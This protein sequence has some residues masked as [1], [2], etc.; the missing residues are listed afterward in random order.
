MIS[1][2]NLLSVVLLAMAVAPATEAQ[3][4]YCPV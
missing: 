1:C 3:S 4:I 2:K